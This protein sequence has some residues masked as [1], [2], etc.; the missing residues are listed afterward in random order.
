M[1]QHSFNVCFTFLPY[2]R[3]TSIRRSA[4][5]NAACLILFFLLVSTA[6]AVSQQTIPLQSDGNLFYIRCSVNGVE[7]DM[8][9]DTGA[10]STVIDRATFNK[11]ALQSAPGDIVVVGSVA[12]AGA[13]GDW[14]MATEVQ[15]SNIRIGSTRIPNSRAVVIDKSNVPALLGQTALSELGLIQIDYAHSQMIV[16]PSLTTDKSSLLIFPPGS[17]IG[18]MELAGKIPFSEFIRNRVGADAANIK[19]KTDYVHFDRSGGTQL[20]VSYYQTMAHAGYD[21]VAVFDSKDGGAEYKLIGYF[22]SA[23]INR[24]EGSIDAYMVFEDDELTYFH[25]CR[26]CNIDYPNHVFPFIRHVVLNGD[27][28]AIK[29]RRDN[30]DII[31]NLEVISKHTVPPLKN[32]SWLG[33]WGSDDGTRKAYARNVVAFYR[34]TLDLPATRSVFYRFYKGSDANELWE[35]I[36]AFCRTNAKTVQ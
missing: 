1:R 4:L 22:P 6:N 7:I 18:R 25:S 10:S 2:S 12:I 3:V 23:D 11:I 36:R 16:Y 21:R 8:V 9:L 15:F 14:A 26:A 5:A 24:I 27:I 13:T 17:K 34:R 30:T 19:I 32:A 20:V 29:Q 33:Q 35:E 28:V 31:Q